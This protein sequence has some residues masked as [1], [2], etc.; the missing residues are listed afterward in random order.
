MRQRPNIW[1]HFFTQQG[2][3][4]NV[5]TVSMVFRFMNSSHEWADY[6]AVFLWSAVIQCVNNGSDNLIMVHW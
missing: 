1:K 2:A 3:F 4:N 6:A 5:F